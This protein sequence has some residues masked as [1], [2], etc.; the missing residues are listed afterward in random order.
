M[1]CRIWKLE[2]LKP[3]LISIYS[4]SPLPLLF[5]PFSIVFS[6]FF[7]GTSLLRDWLKRRKCVK[8][9]TDRIG[10]NGVAKTSILFNRVSSTNFQCKK[11][12]GTEITREESNPICR[13]SID[14][15]G[16]VQCSSCVLCYAARGWNAVCAPQLLIVS[17]NLFSER[18]SCEDTLL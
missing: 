11:G 3:M 7:L 6:F 13:D 9:Q 18:I 8:R 10:M 12:T 4:F 15:S 1:H 14:V 17:P 5:P 16:W 2:F